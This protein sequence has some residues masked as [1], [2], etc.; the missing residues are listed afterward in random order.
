M[1]TYKQRREALVSKM[2]NSSVILLDSGK[3]KHKTTD[4]YFHHVPNRNFFYLTGLNEENVKLMV[5]KQDK[6]LIEFLFIEETT[7]YMRQWVGEKMS[8]EEASSITGV[9]VTNIHYL[10]K[11]DTY[12]R[13]LMTFARGLGVKPPKNLYLDLYRTN[14]TTEP[15]CYSQFNNVIELYKELE[16][17]NVNEFI[18]YLR[19]FKTKDEIKDLQKAIDITEVALNRV[20]NSVKERTNEQEVQADYIHEITLQGSQGYSFNTIMAN[21]VNATVLHYEENNSDLVKENLILCDLGCLYN[22]Y[23]SDITRTYPI[24]GTY[25]ERQKAV[26]EVV[27]KANKEAIEFIKPGITWKEL[28]DFAKS[29]LVKGAKAIGLIK[30]DD[31][32]NKYY[33]HSIGHFLGLD[34]HD[35]GQYGLALEEGMVITIEPGLYIKEEGIGVRIEDDILVTKNGY[36]NLSK[37]IIK[38]INDIEEYMI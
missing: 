8:K 3:A 15:I 26:Y 21:G 14:A 5:V 18:S 11:F 32:I 34:V 25:S 38:E 22:N 23:G 20:M 19:M 29:V 13:S 35:V 12:F 16:I 28:N 6:K 33:Y 10:D 4:Q 24:S 9:D 2:K 27:L 36:K 7:E 37:N 30:E 1:N 17:R 31:E